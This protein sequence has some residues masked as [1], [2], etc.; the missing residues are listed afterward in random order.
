MQPFDALTLRAVLEE[1]KPLLINRKV[2]KV[3]QLGRDEVV[4]YLRSKS[5]MTNLFLSAQAAFG[6]LCL[7]KRPA[8]PY[9]VDRYSE[10]KLKH[11]SGLS[12]SNFSLLLRKHLTGATMIGVQYKVGERVVDFYFSCADEIGKLSRK[13]FTAEIM[14]RHSNL[15]F[16]D[17]ESKKIIASSHIVTKEMSSQREV[18]PGLNYLR[19]PE[20]DKPNIFTTD[21]NELSQHFDNLLLSN[22]RSMN[23]ESGIKITVPVTIE[24]WLINTYT[25]VGRH[26]AEEIVCAAGVPSSIINGDL[27][28]D[29]KDKLWE[30]IR[31]IQ[32]IFSFSPVMKLDLTRFSVLSWWPDVDDEAVWK[33]FP[34]VNDLIEEYFRLTE[35]S[36]QFRQLKERLKS[37]LKTES[38]RLET[39]ISQAALYADSAGDSSLLKKS[40][41]L[42]LANL[43]NIGS[44]QTHLICDDLYSESQEKVTITL[45]P[46]LTPS[47]NAQMFYRR[48]A[49][50]RTKQHTASIALEE[51]S[52]RLD[53]LRS[54]LNRVVEA[55]DSEELQKLKDTFFSKRGKEVLNRIP[56]EARKKAKMRWLTMMSS[57]GWNI[58]AGRNREENEQL[59]SKVAQ[60][61]DLWLHVLGKGGSHV[62]VRV[63]SGKQEPPLSTIKEAA[64]IAARLSKVPPASKVQVV[65]TQRRYVSKLPRD[66]LKDKTGMVRYEHEKI[67]EVDTSAPMPQCMKQLFC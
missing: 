29:M 41:D 32:S 10:K 63:P 12:A 3:Y 42:I 57:D 50:L 27:A 40:G 64:Q 65:Y 21:L 49:K 17:E 55:K 36:E 39:R 18:A 22:S 45:N 61:Q 48:F 26:L 13:V 1:A 66:K 38:E 24:Q 37:E 56:P 53:V 35:K 23:V 5:G 33:K 52:H 62:L 19:P 25:G 7:V 30:K 51:S 60:P 28:P 8:V 2:D 44:G 4:I 9:Q 59:L 67:I 34:A 16:W 54:Q 58:Y 43:I 46:N 47:Q 11:L 15:I 14:G 6:R 31:T 20:Q